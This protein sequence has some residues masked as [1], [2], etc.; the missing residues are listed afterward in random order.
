MVHKFATVAVTVKV[1]VAGPP[2]NAGDTDPIDE[3]AKIT[4]AEILTNL[5]TSDLLKL[6]IMQ[7]YSEIVTEILTLALK[8]LPILRRVP[9]EEEATA[10]ICRNHGNADATYDKRNDKYGGLEVFEAKRPKA[11][12]FGKLTAP[13]LY[14]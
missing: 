8:A 7:S 10:D 12:D 3:A 1:V 9:P 13:R 4:N 5:R 6:F 14:L 11:L 2:A